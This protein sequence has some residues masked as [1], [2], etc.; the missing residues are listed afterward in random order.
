MRTAMAEWLQI[1]APNKDR[2]FDSFE[3]QSFVIMKGAEALR[4]LLNGG[5]NIPT[6]S[7]QL[8]LLET[9]GDMITRATLTD[10]RRAWIAPF[11]RN[12]I[13]GL[14]NAMDDSIDSM[15]QFS[16]RVA[17]YG[18]EHF[19]PEMQAIGDTI[20]RL[21]KLTKDAMPLLRAV[22]KN[23]DRLTGYIM[24][25]SALEE[26][27]ENITEQGVKKLFLENRE[28]DAMIFIAESKLY[29]TLRNV[30]SSFEK[31]GHQIA[32]LV[33]EHR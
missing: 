14:I 15:H 18:V 6:Y 7:R 19:S 9:D 3:R 27:A 24:E 23:G 28:N 22:R 1:F 10:V 33:I 2:F 25:I 21:A 32:D 5:E 20:V 26:E 30:P 17:I 16:K 12:D 31:I 13:S 8:G 11:F 4:K 29:S